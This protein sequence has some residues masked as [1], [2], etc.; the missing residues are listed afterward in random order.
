MKKALI[1]GISGQDGSYLAELLLSKNY[2]VHG[3]IRKHSIENLSRINPLL[4][5]IKYKDSLFLHFGDLEDS[6][7][8][9][10][11]L[12]NVKPDEVY[13]LASQSQV[14]ISFEIPEYTSNV[15][16]LGTLRLLEAI[17]VIGLKT[18]YFQA[19]SCEIFGNTSDIPQNETTICNPKNPYGLSKLYSYHITKIYRDTYNMHNSIGILYNH[20]SPRR[21]Q[22]F[23]TKKITKAIANILSNKQKELYLGNLD[24]KRDWGYAKDYVEAMWLM[25]Q[26]KNPD[27][28]IISTGQ[29]HSVKDFVEEAFSLVNLDWQKYVKIDKNLFRPLDKEVLFVGDN[30]K[31]CNKLGWKPKVSFKQLVKIMVKE[32]LKNS[33]I[34][35]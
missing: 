24:S 23:V 4:E 9:V 34:S 11:I 35:F 32:E 5:D 29:L 25:L 6:L 12:E 17:K 30:S 18:K 33:N 22:S 21:S 28:Y 20:E 13:N 15:T 26:Q 19:S 2:E 1:V 8:L 31:I 7:S 27:D 14:Y 10:K 3:I 16:G